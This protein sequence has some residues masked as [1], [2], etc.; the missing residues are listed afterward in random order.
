MADDQPSLV[1]D[2]HTHTFPP[3][4]VSDRSHL[5]VRDRWF[6]SCYEAPL[7]KI[8]DAS[9]LLAA[10]DEAGVTQAVMC[11]WPW[12]DAGLCREHNDY[13]AATASASGGGVARLG[14]ASPA[15]GVAGRG[16]GRRPEPRG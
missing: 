2:A 13:L 10:M 3:D 9:S 5:L 14:I 15:A 1:I 16:T 6:S 7:A 4:W 8:I 11:G 12:T